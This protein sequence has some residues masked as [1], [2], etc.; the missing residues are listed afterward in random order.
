MQKEGLPPAIPEWGASAHRQQCRT[1]C[2]LF[3]F[4]R[5]GKPGLAT[6]PKTKNALAYS[7]GTVA[8]GL[9]ESEGFEPPDL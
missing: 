2:V 4:V 6:L 5:F 1:S 8:C 3:R 7:E 9:A